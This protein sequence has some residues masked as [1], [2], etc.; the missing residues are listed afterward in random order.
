MFFSSHWTSVHFIMIMM[1]CIRRDWVRWDEKLKSL[2]IAFNLTF[3]NMNQVALHY[4]RISDGSGGAVVERYRN[5]QGASISYY[6]KKS[7]ALH[8]KNSTDEGDSG[9]LSVGLSE[10]N[11]LRPL[12]C[13]YYVSS[14]SSSSSAKTCVCV[15]SQL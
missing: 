12:K 15:C 3:F 6:L 11:N 1:T 8:F 14:S 13:G 9:N 7:T 2:P 10:A 5:K 4:H